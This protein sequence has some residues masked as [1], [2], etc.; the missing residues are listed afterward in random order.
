[1]HRGRLL[2]R[3]NAGLNQYLTV[4]A[5]PAGYGKSTLVSKWLEDCG[6]ST[7][8]FSADDTDND[9]HFFLSY[10]VA[11]VQT[12]RPQYGEETLVILRPPQLPPLP[13]LLPA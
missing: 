6:R 11:A 10:F 2:D 8:W 5:A 4:V 12:V 9:I 3:L 1:M 13:V 7:A